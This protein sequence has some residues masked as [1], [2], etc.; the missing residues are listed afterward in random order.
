M[1]DIGV[2]LTNSQLRHQI[3]NV[4]ADAREAGIEKILVTGTD[5]QA[6][7]EALA[8]CETYVSPDYPELYCTAG[9][10]PHDAKDWNPDTDKQLRELLQN[11]EVVAVGETGLDFNRNYSPKEAQIHA[12]EA[13]LQ[14]AIDLQKPLFLHERDAF[15]TQIDVLKHCGNRLPPVVIHC[16]T[17]DRQS[18][19]AY[20]AQGFYIGITGW[21]CDERRGKGL[22]DIVSTIPL[23]RLMVET[24]APFLLPRNIQPKPESRTNY[25][26]YLPWI[27]KKLAECYR[28]DEEEIRRATKNNAQTFFSI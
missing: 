26:A 22:A 24:D 19:D 25:P 6:S 8:I 4:L 27:T 10:H 16:F 11:P 18:L 9:T 28:L 3:P 14:I 7:Q 12:F 23:D 5:L 17:G 21:V 15:D 1:I 13:Q 2:N 20:L